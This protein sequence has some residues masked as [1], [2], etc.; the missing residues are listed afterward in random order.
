MKHT[1][2]KKSMLGS[3]KKQM[4]KCT[5]ENGHEALLRHVV[6]DAI[7]INNKNQI[8]L[9]KRAEHVFRG[10][11]WGLPGGYLDRDETIKEAVVRE[12]KEETNLKAKPIKLFKVIDNPNRRNEDRQGVCF[13]Y[14]VSVTGDP[15]PQQ[16]EVSEVKW[17]D[18]DKLPKEDEFAFD[19]LEIIHDFLSYT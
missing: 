2:T 5:F 6:V 1:K 4:I 17:V 14:V 7:A 8:L 3:W 10:G 18:L 15:K 12:V 9:V 11:K 16:S 13:I 19:H